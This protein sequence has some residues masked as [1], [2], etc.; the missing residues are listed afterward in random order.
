MNTYEEFI[1]NILITRGRFNCEG[2]K[3]RHHIK[4]RCLGGTN[5]EENLI[6]LYAREHFIAHKLLVDCYP[7]NSSLIYAYACMANLG[8][9]FNRNCEISSEEYEEAKLLYSQFCSKRYS[10]SGNPNYG[11]GRRGKD[12]PRYGNPLPE[13]TK[14]K[15]SK[16]KQLQ[17]AKSI[18]QYD[19]SGNFI[20]QWPGIRYASK[21]LEICHVN[22]V[23]CANHDIKTAGGFIWRYL[24]DPLTEQDIKAANYRNHPRIEVAQFDLNNNFIKIFDSITEAAKSV[25]RKPSNLSICLKKNSQLKDSQKFYTCAD[26]IWKYI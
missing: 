11:K 24:D 26:Y 25:G 21:S 22:I 20:K 5:D 14:L 2:Y 1:N 15:I 23:N 13:S 16:T 4:P 19:K 3:E 7:D 12:N 9:Q 10:G 18:I 8:R 6:D 17:G